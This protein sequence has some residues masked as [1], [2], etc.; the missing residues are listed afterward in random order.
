MANPPPAAPKPTA[1]QHNKNNMRANGERSEMYST[2]ERTTYSIGFGAG[3][4]IQNT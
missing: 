1:N 3:K 2:Q 4:Q